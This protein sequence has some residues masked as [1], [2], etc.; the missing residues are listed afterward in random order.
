MTA[1]RVPP[2]VEAEG[3]L[4]EES[5]VVL[6]LEGLAA[7]PE[8]E[9]ASIHAHLDVCAEC[10]GALAEVR[11]GEEPEKP[12]RPAEM[13]LFAAGTLVAGRYKI[14]RYINGGGMGDVYEAEDTR[15]SGSPI[16]LKT[17]SAVAADE[18][19]A[20]RRLEREVR[21]AL[22][23][24]HAHACR[25]HHLDVHRLPGH[26]GT[27]HFITMELIDGETLQE[28]I[29]RGGPLREACALELAKQ[30]LGAL[31]AAHRK[32]VLHRDLKPSNVMLRRGERVDGVVMDFGL[33]KTLEEP[34]D[35]RITDS[36][37]FVGSA[38][39]AAPEQL[40][41]DPLTAATDIYAFGI[42]LFEALT[43]RLPFERQGA[44]RSAL[45]RLEQKAPR[46]SA[47]APQLSPGWDRIVG[48]CLERDAKRRFASASE[49]ERALGSLRLG[50]RNPANL[51]LAAG[52][53]SLLAVGSVGL[54]L[55]SWPRSP[56]PAIALEQLNAEGHGAGEDHSPP[57]PADS[58]DHSVP[59]LL[60][61]GG[62]GL[63][64]DA[65]ALA[66]PQH[67]VEAPKSSGTQKQRNSARSARTGQGVSGKKTTRRATQA[68]PA[69]PRPKSR[70]A[71]LKERSDAQQ[72]EQTPEL[73]DPSD[74][75][76]MPGE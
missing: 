39:Y 7:F 15:V 68:R 14:V 48:R 18:E 31:T 64:T 50:G 57:T 41:G 17:I 46:P 56:D 40:V 55:L 63:D 19:S 26:Q 21:T 74:R 61:Q 54:V 59:A 36:S 60:P 6:A 37:A 23:V 9:R 75:F 32:G 69:R 25:V 24:S 5:L 20:I 65:A 27:I 45:Q 8:S 34:V 35:A 67:K 13:R 38:S 62:M 66:Q 3:H 2:L 29:K 30:L 52:L 47:F 43:G 44:L 12:R 11:R 70:Q 51:R 76:L 33:A 22:L 73:L 16:A 28:R 71:D 4:L 72:R 49:V 58:T 1:E 10:R 42:V 53:G